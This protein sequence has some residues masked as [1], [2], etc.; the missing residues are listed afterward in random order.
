MS[1]WFTWFDRAAS[2]DNHLSKR[3][4]QLFHIGRMIMTQ[5]SD[6]QNALN[7]L[8]ADAVA[9]KQEVQTALA[10]L[11]NEVANLKTQIANGTG[12]S[13]A[14]LDNLLGQIVGIDAQVQ[15]ISVPAQ[16]PVE[17]PAA[18]AQAYADPVPTAGSVAA[19]E[20]QPAGP[21]PDPIPSEPAPAAAGPVADPSVVQAAAPT[22]PANPGAPSVVEPVPGQPAP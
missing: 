8:A 11:T 2:T 20:A 18:V 4:A 9:E 14:D 19:A 15:A 12:V 10:A 16:T 7:K 6:I 3:L 5:L 22:D 1:N 21:G 17:A 13:P